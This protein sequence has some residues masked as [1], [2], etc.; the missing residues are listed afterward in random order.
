MTSKMFRTTHSLFKITVAPRTQPV[1]WRRYLGVFYTLLAVNMLSLTNTIMKKYSHVHPFNV[2]IWY[3]P[4]AAAV[5]LV[6]ILYHK[7]YARGSLSQG[8]LPLKDNKKNVA[9][10][11]L[12]GII[13]SII[14]YL[15]VAAFRYI[16]AADLR[17]VISAVVIAVFLFGWLFLGEKCGVVPIVTAIVAVCGIGIMTRPPILTGKEEF[18]QNTLVSLEQWYIF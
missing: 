1:G 10:V 9:L 5:A 8:L 2:G 16:S 17:T 13:T 18:D 7:C 4:T 3:S 11:F 12:R 15:S 6:C 14:F